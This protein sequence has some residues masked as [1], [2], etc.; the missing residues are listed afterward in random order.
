MGF[1]LPP[2]T[3]TVTGSNCAELTLDWLVTV[4]A[5]VSCVKVNW[6]AVLVALVP[7]L[8]TTVMLTV[9]PDPDGEVAVICVS[10]LTVKLAAVA[11]R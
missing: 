4:T 2:L 1:P 3:E 10:L 5:G 6:S 7:A 11:P 9:P 8:V